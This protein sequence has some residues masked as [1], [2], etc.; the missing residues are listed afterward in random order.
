[1]G[2]KRAGRELNA[3]GPEEF[4]VSLEA[5]PH[6]RARPKE[7]VFRRDHAAPG[8][9]WK[10]RLTRAMIR[11]EAETPPGPNGTSSSDEE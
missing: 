8:V 5:P 1:M 9:V 6:Q 4:R 3:D 10:A 2:D 7:L 11:G